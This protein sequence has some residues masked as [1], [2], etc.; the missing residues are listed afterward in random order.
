[1]WNRKSCFLLFPRFKL[2][3]KAN[4]FGNK[5]LF[6]CCCHKAKVEDRHLFLFGLGYLGKALAVQLGKETSGDNFKSHSD[7]SLIV[8]QGWKVTG[9]K[10]TESVEKEILERCEKVFIM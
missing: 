1:M 5:S 2:I 9:T 6:T 10:K 4:K 8:R 7:L 3:G